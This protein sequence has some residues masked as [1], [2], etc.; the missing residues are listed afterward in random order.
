MIA[1]DVVTYSFIIATSLLLLYIPT[2]VGIVFSFLIVY[3]RY[4]VRSSKHC[5]C[6]YH[7]Y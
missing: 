6:A 5:R 7:N 3:T 4:C 1:E 2:A